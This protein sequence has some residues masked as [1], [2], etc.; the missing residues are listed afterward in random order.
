MAGH[1]PALFR[2]SFLRTIADET[3]GRA[4]LGHNNLAEPF[5]QIARDNGSYYLL[6]FRPRTPAG[7]TFRE[8]RVRVKR[9]DV[10]V[11]A[12]QGYGEPGGS[13][14]NAAMRATLARAWA[15]KTVADLLDRPLP[16]G[17]P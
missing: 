15:G 16:P 9:D 4:I 3:G 1:G 17:S 2:W 11:F 6:G 7:R 5:A 10:R 13:G 12:R 8:L 14:R